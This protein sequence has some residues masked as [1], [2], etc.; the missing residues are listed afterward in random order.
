MYET[1]KA[2]GYEIFNS[3]YIGEKEIVI[4]ELPYDSPE[5]YLCACYSSNGVIGSYSDCMVSDNYA[6]IMMLFAD[7]VREQAE[8]IFTEMQSAQVP[9]EDKKC[10]DSSRISF[11][12]Y[13]DDI[14]NKVIVIKP[15]ALHRE[16]RTALH[17]IQLCT[18]GFG[19]RGNSRGSACYCTNLFTGKSTRFERKDILGVMKADKIPEWADK[20]L[21]DIKHKNRSEKVKEV[22]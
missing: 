6:E 12:S 11:I 15:E 9:E 16:Y 4:G 21:S 19:S 3:I 2:G 14:E 1:R 8:N 17:Q 18:G 7:R 20:T 5:K 13:K 22:R 10:V